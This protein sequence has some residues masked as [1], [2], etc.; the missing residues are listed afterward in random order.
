MFQIGAGSGLLERALL[1]HGVNV[2]AVE[3][4]SC[5]N[6]YLPE[7]RMLRV[8]TSSSLHSEAMVADVLLFCYPRAIGLVEQYLSSQGAADQI[9][10]IT[11]R[12]EWSTYRTL[13]LAGFKSV[14]DVPSSSNGNPVLPEYEVLCLASSPI[15]ADGLRPRT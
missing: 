2:Q 6:L 9:I 15:S 1:D 14:V 5:P 8:P 3:V 12:D 10:L 7:E 13:L 4:I 11:H